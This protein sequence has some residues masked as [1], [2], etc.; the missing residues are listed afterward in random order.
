MFIYRNPFGADPRKCLF[1]GRAFRFSG[2][3]AW[4][5]AAKIETQFHHGPEFLIGHLIPPKIADPT[6]FAKG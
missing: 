4:V 3:K 2:G 1:H 6:V 5:E